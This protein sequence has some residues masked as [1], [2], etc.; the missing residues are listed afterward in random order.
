MLT[1]KRVT[2]DAAYLH[3]ELDDG[4]IISTPLAWYPTLLSA[5]E[6]QKANKK[7]IARNTMIEW[8]DLDMHLDVEEMLRV[9]REE[10]VA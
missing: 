8:S 2:L 9:D 3:V 7:L 6:L 4:R 10:K 1:C 5:T